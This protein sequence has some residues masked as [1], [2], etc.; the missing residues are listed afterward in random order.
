[1]RNAVSRLVVSGT[2]QVLG[3]VKLHKAADKQIQAPVI[4]IIEPDSA[5]RPSRSGNPSLL[6]NVRKSAIA[7][8]VIKNA[9]AVLGHV[10][11][12][13]AI[14]VVIANGHSL[15]ITPCRYPGFLCYIGEC[16]IA[17]VA[18]ESIPERRSRSKKVTLSAVDKINVQPAVIVVVEKSATRSRS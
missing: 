11:I 1:M 3:F 5:R 14:S 8:V 18:V 13:K 4:V 9:S 10:D 2:G 6:G 7:V 17:I 16:A 15:P 12:R